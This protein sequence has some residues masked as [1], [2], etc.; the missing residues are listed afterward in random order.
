MQAGGMNCQTFSQKSLHARKKP[1]PPPSLSTPC[2]CIK[3][4][5]LKS[6]K[7]AGIIVKTRQ[8]NSYLNK[9]K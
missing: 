7:T 5:E 3:G 9:I 6:A 8:H 1:P 2:T 4:K